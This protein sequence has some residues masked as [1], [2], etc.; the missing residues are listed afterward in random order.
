MSCKRSQELL[1]TAGSEPAEIQ[2]AE[3]H[4]I[5]GDGAVAMARKAKR[6]VVAKGTKVIDLAITR[7]AP[8]DDELRALVLG[9]T[10]RLR[11]PT[12]R[13]GDTLVVGFTADGY[14]ALLAKR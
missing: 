7:T 3:K 11:A 14:R 2:R 8:T 12:L 1:A 5:D 6:L 4:P 10:G 9:P 13:V